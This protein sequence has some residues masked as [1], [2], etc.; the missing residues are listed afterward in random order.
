MFLSCCSHVLLAG[1]YSTCMILYIQSVFG[2]GSKLSWPGENMS[3]VKLNLEK[4]AFMFLFSLIYKS[5]EYN[6]SMRTPHFCSIR[7]LNLFNVLN[8]SRDS[9]VL[10]V[11][12]RMWSWNSSSGDLFFSGNA[13]Y[14]YCANVPKPWWYIFG[15]DYFISSVQNQH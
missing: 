7:V 9:A 10:K 2:N 5:L 1:N 14:H 8:V 4:N 12:H 11:A 13:W 3:G 15:K 6:C